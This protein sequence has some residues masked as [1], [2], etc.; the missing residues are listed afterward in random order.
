MLVF[1]VGVTVH[2]VHLSRTD[3]CHLEMKLSCGNKTFVSRRQSHPTMGRQYWH[4]AVRTVASVN[5]ILLNG[6][7][8]VGP[9]QETRGSRI[10]YCGCMVHCD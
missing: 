8:L 2:K 7:C 6:C 1:P 5:V 10:S 9:C 3:K 4:I